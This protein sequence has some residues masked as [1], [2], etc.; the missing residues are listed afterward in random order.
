MRISCLSLMLLSCKL[1]ITSEWVECFQP[2]PNFCTWSLKAF[3]FF[4]FESK[5]FS[6]FSGCAVFLP[7]LSYCIVLPQLSYCNMHRL[8]CGRK[9]QKIFH[10]FSVKIFLAKS[11]LCSNTL[12]GWI[13]RRRR[14]KA[15]RLRKFSIEK[16]KGMKTWEDLKLSSLKGKIKCFSLFQHF[17]SSYFHKRNK[18]VFWRQFVLLS[19]VTVFFDVIARSTCTRVLCF[20]LASLCEAITSLF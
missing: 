16:T 8:R 10:P 19:P 20:F 2:K 4:N 9:N 5:C 11:Q 6:S 13:R 15:W 3:F 14:R 18:Y 12:G 7:K 1:T 17:V